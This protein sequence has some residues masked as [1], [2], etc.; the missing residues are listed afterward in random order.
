MHI[1]NEIYYKELAYVIVEADKYQ[2][3]QSGQPMV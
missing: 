1:Q 2:D 3:L